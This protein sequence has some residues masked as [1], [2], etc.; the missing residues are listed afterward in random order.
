MTEGNIS[1]ILLNFAL[2]LMLGNLFQQLYNLADSLIVGM[3]LDSS[4]L[5]AVSSSGNLIMLLVGVFQG[6]SM[7]GGVVISKY[8][9]AGDKQSVSKAVHTTIFFG[10]FCGILLTLIGV[11]FAPQILVLMDTPTDVIDKSVTY[12]SIYFAGSLSF[13]LYNIFVGILQAIGD[14]K[15]PLQYLI[16]SSCI[17]VGLDILF[18]P[19]L[20]FGVGSAALATIIAQTLSALFCFYRLLTTK[21]CYQ[22]R[23]KQLRIDFA[24]LK[25]ILIIG[26]PA[27]FQTS[28]ISFANVF[29]QSHIN[30]FGSLAM[31]GNGA[32]MK[33]EGFAFLPVTSFSMAL[34][35]FVSQNLGAG[36]TTRARIGSYIGLAWM[37]GL[38]ALIGLLFFFFSP[39]ILPAFDSNPEVIAYGVERS[40]TVSLFFFLMAFSYGMAAI[41]RGAGNSITPM[42]VMLICWCFVRVSV[43]S[44]VMPHFHNIR[45]IYTLYPITWSISTV[46]YLCYMRTISWLKR[47]E[48]IS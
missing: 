35:T 45:I 38:S 4:D 8:Y 3:F 17:N 31:A 23:F 2:P 14:S 20:G 25:Q 9:G 47:K 16:L 40:N 36:D 13:V 48:N 5:A 46:T 39:L 18:I 30:S 26:I 22:V 32:Y 37:L 33:I 1:K 10:F 11:L 21:D 29:I 27:G 34:T 44:L 12:F 43:L 24:L 19:V 6:L 41:L 42:L 28:I 15:R 7:G